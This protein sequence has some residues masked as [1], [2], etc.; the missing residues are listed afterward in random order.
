LNALRTRQPKVFIKTFGCQMNFRD[1]EAVLG[2]MVDCGYSV[3]NAPEDADVILINTCSVRQHAE[4]R[5][6]SVAGSFKKLVTPL[7]FRTKGARNLNEG[8]NHSDEKIIGMIGC[9]AQSLK[10]E[11]FKKLPHLDF[12]AGPSEISRIPKIIEEIREKRQ[13]I[14][15]VDLEKLRPEKLYSS[16]YTEDKKHAYVNISE[17]CDNYCSYCLVPYVRGTLRHRKAKNIIK[18]IKK[19]VSLGITDITLLGQNVNAYGSE[20]CTVNSLQEKQKKKIDFVELLKMV[21]EVEGLK[22]F[23]FVTSH[24]KDAS[25]ELFYAMRDLPKLKKY[26]HL[27]VQSGS[28]RILKLMNRGY[29]LRRYQELVGAYR[30]IAPNAEL[31]T[32]IIVGFPSEADEDFQATHDLLKNMKFNSAYIFKYSPRPKTKAQEMPDDVPKDI[33]EKRHQILLDMQKKISKGLKKSLCILIFVYSLQFTV[34]SYGYGI[35]LSK[36]QEYFLRA[37]Y[38]RAI[39]ECQKE[40]KGTSR[41][42]EQAEL[43]YLCGQAYLKLGNIDKAEESFLKVINDCKTF[44]VCDKAVIGLGDVYFQ[45][46][47]YLKAKEFYAQAKDSNVDLRAQS[48][49]KLAQAEIKL[50]NSEIAKGYIV[51]IK[52]DFPQSPEAQKSDLLTTGSMDVVYTVQVGAFSTERNAQKLV[53]KLRE[54]GFETYVEPLKSDDGM[55]YRVRVGRYNSR[56]EAETIAQDLSQKGFPTKIFP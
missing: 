30:K 23:S 38:E 36:A 21:N 29:T 43:Y 41:K 1:S 7:R 35:S 27:P 6:I 24:P 9:A 40:I 26:L 32:D 25:I 56:K 17:G 22:S 42:S 55:L 10:Q 16:G 51:K 33:K 37:E 48:L 45:R 14:A 13:K 5:A 2:M 52:Q 11:L 46:E 28:D 53:D 12:I 47:D 18:E 49:Y 31:T 20:R 44:A 34:Y 19:L 39:S 3:A 54:S 15:A 8:G 4:E 50:G